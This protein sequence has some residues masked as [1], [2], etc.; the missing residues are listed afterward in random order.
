MRDRTE[1][2]LVGVGGQGVIL[3]GKI[4]GAAAIIEG[5]NVVQTVEYTDAARGGFSKSEVVISQQD[6]A[7]PQVLEPDA[8]LALSKQAYDMYK[9]KDCLLIYDSDVI[10]PDRVSEKIKGYSITKTAV[11]MGSMK[12]LNM[13]SLGLIVSCTGLVSY[14]SAVHAL[15]QGVPSKL[16]E[17]N[18]K[19]FNAGYDMGQQK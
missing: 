2:A 1:V 12:V 18:L 3:I 10:T 15:K 13:I 19:A 6:I 8:V 16:L 7:Y 17:L 14:E 4:L 11:N 5:K 9:D